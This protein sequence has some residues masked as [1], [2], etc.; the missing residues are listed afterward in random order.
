MSPQIIQSLLIP[1]INNAWKP[2]DALALNSND[3][4]S[5]EY[6]VF[7]RQENELIPLSVYS[8]LDFKAL[9][10]PIGRNHFAS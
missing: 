6:E 10:T 3:F 1:K 5:S 2:S 4:V 9:S 7:V 8:F